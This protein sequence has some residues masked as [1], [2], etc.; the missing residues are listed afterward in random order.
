LLHPIDAAWSGLTR[1]LNEYRK[2]RDFKKTS[3]PAGGARAA[4]GDRV[5]VVQKHAATRLHYDLRL[6]VD[7]VLKSWAVPKG[8]SMN[9]GDKRLAVQVE[10]HPFEYRKFEGSIPKG[11]YGGGEVII[12]DEGTYAPEGDMSTRDQLAR[13]ELKFQLHGEKLRGSF[14]IVRLRKPGTKNEWLLIKHRDSFADDKWDAEQHAESVVSGRTLED[15]AEGRPASRD[16]RVVNASELDGAMEAPMPKM[17]GGVRAT[18]AEL[19]EKPFSDPNWIFEIKWD[20]VRA[21]AEIKGGKT[22]LWARS[23]RDVT[24]EYP[25]FKNLAEKFRVKN[26]IV[27]GEIVTLDADGRSNF[28]KLQNRLGVQNPSQKL[29]QS[30]PL[31]YYAFDLMYADGYDLRKAPL[32]ER[33]ELLRK[34]LI[35]NE[36]VH[37]SEHIAEKGEELFEAAR[38]KGLEGLIAK[39]KDSAYSG[40]RTSA[41]LKLK[42]VNELDAVV[43]GY[44]EGRGSRKYFGALVL[45]LYDD[46]ELKFIGSAGT[47][48]DE[49]TQQQIF[50]KLQKLGTPHDPFGTAPALREKVDWVKPELV[51]R[52]KYANWTTDD[53][54]RAPV[55]LSLRNDRKAKDCTFEDAGPEPVEEVASAPK[56]KLAKSERV[57]TKAGK[58]AERK[59]E[60]LEETPAETRAMKVVVPQVTAKSQAKQSHPTGSGAPKAASERPAN[61]IAEVSGRG[62]RQGFL[63]ERGALV[64]AGLDW[65]GDGGV[66][67]ARRRDAVHPCQQSRGIALSHQSGLHRS[68]SVVEPGGKPGPAGLRFLRSGPD[69]GNAVFGCVVYR[70][71]DLQDAEVDPHAVFPEDVGRIWISY[72]YSFG[73]AVQLRTDADVRGS[74]GSVGRGGKSKTHDVRAN[75]KQASQGPHPDRR[76][77]ECEWETVG[78]RLFGASGTEGTGLDAAGA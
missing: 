49:G 22:T 67:G 65:H 48:F 77:A 62:W 66:R 69:T 50:D 15:I 35:G 8:P 61:G 68:Q 32:V 28:Q 40:T 71:R 42:I 39:I 14:V 18:L 64:F 24:K 59:T 1:V 5:F 9:P 55:F 17:P 44:T 34:V 19:R 7:G 47:G 43:A 12:W 21:L 13:G 46:S 73:S 70:E 53:H 20:G 76:P 54:L 2:K 45:G 37:Y 30:V 33:K 52:V 3:E 41:W 31:D 72:L 26:A 6:E 36:R 74:G 16:R 75:G 56:A 60:S 25:E 51:A 11:E 27:D 57:K 78:M 4:S 23:G 63:P 38:A 58:T 10:D 29:M